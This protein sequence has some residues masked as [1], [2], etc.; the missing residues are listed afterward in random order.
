MKPQQPLWGH[1]SDKG[2]WSLSI[3]MEQLLQLE[4]LAVTLWEQG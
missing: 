4:F 2:L 1:P 3:S